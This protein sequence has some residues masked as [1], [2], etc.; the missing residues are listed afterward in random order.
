MKLIRL[1]A[2]VLAG[3]ATL[4]LL[5]RRPGRLRLDRARAA[6]RLAARGGARYVASAPRLFA[7]AGEQRQLLREDLALQTAE[8]V[9]DTLGSMKG[10]MMKIGQMA[11][12]VDDGLSPA[13]RH[14]LGRLQDSVPP[15][16]P[17][18][19]ATVVAEELGVPPER[20]FARWD[21]RPIAA[22]SIG[23]VHRAVTLDGRAVA[24]KVQY[25][26]ITETIAADLRNVALLRRMLRIAAP[27]QDVDALLSELRDRIGEE[28]DYRREAANQRL[29]AAYY[30][31]HPTIG[32]PGVVSELST[33]R[34]LTSE[35]SSGA[36]FA[37]LAT[38][39][40]HERDL[41]AETIYRFVF[42]SLYDVRAFNG[43][44]HPGNYLFQRGGRVTFL[45]FGLVRH[46]SPAELSAAHGHGPH[47]LRRARPRGVPPRPGAR[48]IPAPRRAA[49]HPGDR[50]APGR[51]LRHH[52][53]TR[54]GDHHQRLRLLGRA[55]LLRPAQP[56]RRL[57]QRPP[58]VRDP[59][60]HQSRPVRRARRAVRHRRLA[61][62]LRG[63]LALRPGPGHYPDGRGR[64]RVARTPSGCRVMTL[65]PEG[66]PR[67]ACGGWRVDLDRS[68][69][70]FAVRAAGQSVRGRLPLTGQVLVTEPIEDST[71][72]LAARAS[73]ASTGSS[74]LDR[75]LA[76][77]GFLDAETFPEISFR[78]EM[79][80]WVPAGWRAVGR[81]QVKGAEHELA[82]RFDLRLDD[83]RR[84]GP[85]R[86][87]VAGTLVIDSRWIARQWI[88]ALDR[89]IEMT[90]C[91]SLEPDVWV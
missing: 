65:R 87:K 59:P 61:R 86:L 39:P 91:L 55:P 7:A 15:M 78:S 38:W 9:V 67:L 84:G 14:T 47:D 64:G 89:R 18:L 43:D 72:R 54:A 31:G 62:H 8:D 35:L 11:S 2:A 81:L 88:P 21:P 10:V 5:R 3:A 71:V 75:L 33:R 73:A 63:D 30:D 66:Q 80:A 37:E 77:P 48:R 19:A 46:F 90:C 16:S 22:A 76:G 20:A 4:V 23:Q 13:V 74:W 68:H 70:S 40:Q 82:C 29:L 83:P 24:V 51:L 41:A 12:Y 25:P 79:L 53:R 32:I 26:G 56:R 58:A 49:Q 45:D 36:R 27:A 44:P 69:A 34:L 17:R 52:P 57:H 50:R 6:L 42:R 60:A 85:P 28:L 1:L